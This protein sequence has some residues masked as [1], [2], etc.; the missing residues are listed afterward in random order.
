V[1]SSRDTWIAQSAYNFR[2]QPVIGA[3]IAIVFLVLFVALLR[4]EHTN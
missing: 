3:F 1:V 2:M 4:A